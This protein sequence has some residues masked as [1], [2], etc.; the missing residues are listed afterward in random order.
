MARRE[1]SNQEGH[2]LSFLR[3][4]S[5][6]PVGEVARILGIRGSTLTGMLDRLEYRGFITRELHPDDRRSFLLRITPKGKR[7]ANSVQEFVERFEA[8]IR[9]RISAADVKGFDRVMAAI[10]E[11]TA[12]EVRNPREKT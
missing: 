12:V 1:V 10:T 8:D 9:K 4:Y 2:L 3:S 11:V 7:G 5:P 6:S